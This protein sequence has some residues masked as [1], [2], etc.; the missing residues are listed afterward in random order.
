MG[1]S[2]EGQEGRHEGGNLGRQSGEGEEEARR[3]RV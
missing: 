1:G 2:G 3:V